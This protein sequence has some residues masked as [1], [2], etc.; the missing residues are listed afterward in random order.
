MA[1]A[2]TG[3]AGGTRGHRAEGRGLGLVR[4]ASVLLVVMGVLARAACLR[5][6]A[7]MVRLILMRLIRVFLATTGPAPPSGPR[8][9]RLP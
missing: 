4:F 9:P 5:A 6:G 7:L 8:S 1:P 2:T 3:P